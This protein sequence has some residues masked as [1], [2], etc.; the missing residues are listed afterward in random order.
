MKLSVTQFGLILRIELHVNQKK[1]SE[2]AW[3][4]F[5]WSLSMAFFALVFAK[6][7]VAHPH[8]TEI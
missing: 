3:K 6:L 2:H 4:L 5:I 7:V 8:Y 1:N